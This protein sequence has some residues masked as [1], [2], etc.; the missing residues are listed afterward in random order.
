MLYRAFRHR[1]H[2]EHAHAAAHGRLRSAWL[3]LRMLTGKGA[4]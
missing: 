1:Q 4:A 3:A 2:A